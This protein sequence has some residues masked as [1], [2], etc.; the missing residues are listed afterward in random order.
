ML[1]NYVNY[2]KFEG[3]DE[4]GQFT[5]EFTGSEIAISLGYAYNIPYTTIHRCKCTNSSTLESYS[6]WGAVDLGAIFIDE[7]DVN[8]GLVIR[9]IGTQFT[10]YSG[11][12]KNCQW[13]FY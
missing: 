2:G 11:G 12:R 1:V 13:R 7:N 3:Y 9:N 4:N 5:S 10:S 8:W 6:S